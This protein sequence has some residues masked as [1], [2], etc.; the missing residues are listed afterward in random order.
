MHGKNVKTVCSEDGS[1]QIH[2]K[3]VKTLCSEDGIS[4]GSEEFS[5]RYKLI[6]WQSFEQYA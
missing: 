5:P 6:L 3:I 2:Q 4:Q 1:L